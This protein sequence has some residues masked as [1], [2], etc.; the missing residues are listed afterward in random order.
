MPTLI[1]QYN[2]GKG[3]FAAHSC[4]L[5]QALSHDHR[6]TYHSLQLAISAAIL[7]F[8]AD[9]DTKFCTLNYTQTYLNYFVLRVKMNSKHRSYDTSCTISCKRSDHL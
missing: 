7:Y 4:D 9:I 6:A 5:M 2:R 1:A 8:M 3:S